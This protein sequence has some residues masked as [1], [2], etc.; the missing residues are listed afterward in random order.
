[1]L[2]IVRVDGLVDNLPT[3]VIDEAAELGTLL[4]FPFAV[5]LRIGEVIEDV[6]HFVELG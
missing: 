3:I 6:A 1:L 5:A 4:H 2:E